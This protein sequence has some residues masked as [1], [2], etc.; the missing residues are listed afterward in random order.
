MRA[1]VQKGSGL[2]MSA[3]CRLFYRNVQMAAHKPFAA[4]CKLDIPVHEEILLFPR[5]ACGQRTLKLSVQTV[6]ACLLAPHRKR[7][8]T[9]AL[10]EGR[11]GRLRYV[12][13]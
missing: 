12:L 9:R 8:T 2:R 10:S 5:K 4:K 7:K 13:V 11:V 6:F 3:L 1:L